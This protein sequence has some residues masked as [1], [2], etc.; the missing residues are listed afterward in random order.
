MK[1]LEQFT[2]PYPLTGMSSEDI[3]RIILELK[4]NKPYHPAIKKFQIY[5]DNMTKK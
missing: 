5:W 4:I 1:E 2:S 3:Q